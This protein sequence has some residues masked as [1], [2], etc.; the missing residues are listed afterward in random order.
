MPV[1]LVGGANSQSLL[2]PSL[3]K[4]KKIRAV[5]PIAL[6]I[7]SIMLN[8]NCKESVSIIKKNPPQLVMV[9]SYWCF[10]CDLHLTAGNPHV[11]PD[12]VSHA[13]GESTQCFVSG[14][15]PRQLRDREPAGFPSPIGSCL[16]SHAQAVCPAL[17]W[18]SQ[19]GE[20][21]LSIP[22]EFAG[23]AVLR[24]GRGKQP[25]LP[26]CKLSR[27]ARELSPQEKKYGTSGVVYAE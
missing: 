21:S 1:C 27:S 6:M 11:L 2:H 19:R 10:T 3:F 22:E 18:Q 5:E 9:A 23:L 25:Y 20:A 8:S 12:S 15:P 4:W 24:E 17:R 14:E 26:T 13:G 7:D 16:G